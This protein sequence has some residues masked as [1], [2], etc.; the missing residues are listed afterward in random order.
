MSTNRFGKEL[1][2]YSYSKE[3]LAKFNYAKI[4]TKNGDILIKLFNEETPNT[5]ANFV[6]LANDGFYD[7]L[8]FH[9]VISGFMAQGGCPEKSGMGGP[10]WAI[11]CEVDAPKQ[12]HKRG[13]LSMAHAG[14]DTG[15]SQFFICFVPCSH[16]DGN[17][18]VFGEIEAIQRDSFKTL[19]STKQGDEIIKIEI[20][21]AI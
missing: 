5:V 16:L 11:K 3:E 9:R 10:D 19:D 4:T 12:S 21:E 2:E 18:T 17:H 8:N 14:R 20:L 15:G 13:S 6:T 7:G 1:K